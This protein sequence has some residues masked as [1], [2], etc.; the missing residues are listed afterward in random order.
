[1]QQWKENLASFIILNE[2]LSS[3]MSQEIFRE[4]P[5]TIVDAT[6]GNAWIK[7]SISRLDNLDVEN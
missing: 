5:K 1:M 2:V 3:C 7:I 4:F 6:L